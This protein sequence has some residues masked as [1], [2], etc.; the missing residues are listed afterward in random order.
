MFTK[1]LVLGGH[2]KAHCL[3]KNILI[4]VFLNVYY[5]KQKNKDKVCDTNHDFTVSV[6]LYRTAGKPVV[7]ICILSKSFYKI[8]QKVVVVKTNVSI[9][10][11]KSKISLGYAQFLGYSGAL[12]FVQR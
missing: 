12:R 7:H 9:W 5:N 11:M 6:V 4:G 2:F 10:L 3:P 8:V 1:G